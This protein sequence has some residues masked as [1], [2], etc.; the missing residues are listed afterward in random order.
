MRQT[1]LFAIK[2]ADITIRFVL[3]TVIAIPQ[4]IIPFLSEDTEHVDE[5]YKVV[6]LEEPLLV[7]SKE[8]ASALWMKIYPYE[9]RYLRVYPSLTEKDGCQVACQL[10]GDGKHTL[11]YPKERWETYAGEWQFLHLIGIEEVLI[12]HQAFLLHSSVVEMNGKVFLFS[13]PSGIG[14]STQASLWEQYLGADILNGDRCIIRRKTDGFYGCGSP[15]C[16]TSK[17]YRAEQFP[18]GGILLLRQAEENAI[19]RVGKEAFIEIYEQSIVNSWNGE[20][21]L[22]LSDL[23]GEL[24]KEIPVYELF[25]RPDQDAVQLAYETLFEG[26]I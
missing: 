22:Q 1:S 5:E 2:F 13:G 7:H 14:T 26:E 9:G 8:A 23:I 16:G 24:L 18:V 11:Y 20:F 4:R 17:I 12:R 21:V 19:R 25:C 6:L 15:W 10:S 3:P